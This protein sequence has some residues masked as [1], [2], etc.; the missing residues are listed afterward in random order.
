PKVQHGVNLAGIVV[1]VSGQHP[2][3]G[4]IK[5]AQ[6]IDRIEFKQTAPHLLERRPEIVRQAVENAPV[7][8]RGQQLDQK[9]EIENEHPVPVQLEKRALPEDVKA[10]SQE[11]PASQF[12]S[13]R[14][15]P[16]RRTA[17]QLSPEG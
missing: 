13:E 17:A 7:H 8:A 15:A 5:R 6:Q 1:Q 11:G 3:E 4:R 14:L 9:I 2:R 12:L 10:L 16:G